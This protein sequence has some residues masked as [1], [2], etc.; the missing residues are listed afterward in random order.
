M[1]PDISKRFADIKRYGEDTFCEDRDCD[2]CNGCSEEQEYFEIRREKG[3]LTISY[4]NKLAGISRLFYLD[5]E[6]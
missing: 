1:K 3:V 6:V 5:E 2:G 4:F